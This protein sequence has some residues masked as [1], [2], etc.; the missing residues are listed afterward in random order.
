MLPAHKS[1]RAPASTLYAQVF[2]LKGSPTIMKPWRTSIISYICISDKRLT[3]QRSTKA[4]IMCMKL[5]VSLL[6]SDAQDK[7]SANYLHSIKADQSVN[8][9]QKA[10][11]LLC[12]FSLI[13]FKKSLPPDFLPFPLLNVIPQL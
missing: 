3:L 8:P 10:V 5:E 13:Q 12:Q 7:I 1:P 11:I 9:N 2:P 4:S 6:H